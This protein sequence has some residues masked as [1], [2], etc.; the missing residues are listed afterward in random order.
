MGDDVRDAFEAFDRHWAERRVCERRTT[1]RELWLV[2]MRGHVVM[3][4]H[5][6]SARGAEDR[7]RDGR[8][9]FGLTTAVRNSCLA[10]ASARSVNSIQASVRRMQRRPRSS[11]GWRRSGL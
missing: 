11:G 2:V 6:D 5:D 7:S 3:P 1:R 9:I 4:G 8:G 10:S